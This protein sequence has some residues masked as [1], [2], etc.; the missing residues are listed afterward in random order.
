[1]TIRQIT[2]QSF[3]KNKKSECLRMQV[4]A[5]VQAGKVVVQGEYL[6]VKS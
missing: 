4:N 3:H 6:A 5:L 1:M 2:R